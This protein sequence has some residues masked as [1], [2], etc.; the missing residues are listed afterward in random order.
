MLTLVT[1]RFG[2]DALGWIN[3]AILGLRY[4]KLMNTDC[5]AR[6]AGT[7]CILYCVNINLHFI[8][9]L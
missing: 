8:N 3:V 1:W 4:L 5:F 7:A 9:I 2:L 6:K